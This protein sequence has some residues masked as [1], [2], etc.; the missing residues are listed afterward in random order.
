[1][2]TPATE[3]DRLTTLEDVRAHDWRMLV[4]GELVRARS[5][6]TVTTESPALE[7]P[8]A[9]VPEAD[10]EDI[11]AA[12]RAAEDGTAQWQTL[13]VQERA[14]RVRQMAERLAG[15]ADEFGFLDSLDGG[16][17]ITAMRGDVPLAVALMRM[18]CDWALELKGTTIP[19]T[20]DHLHYTVREPYGV[21][22]RIIPYNHPL[23]FA[24][25]RSAPAL[26]AG[27]AVI[28]KTPDQTP[29]SALRMGEL[30]HDLFPPGVLNI[31]TGRGAVTGDALVRHPR[32]KRIAFIGSVPT[33]QSVLRAASETGIKHVTLELG[34]KNPMIVFP[35]AD[36]DRAVEAAVLGMNFHWTG[37]QSCGSTS[38]LLLH[39]SL[40]DELVPRVVARVEEIKV[41]SPMDAATEMG[42][43]VSRA[44]YDKVMG[45]IE[46]G[47]EE[48]AKLL[49][50]GARP[51]GAE[52][53]KGWF[54][55]PTV[56]GNVESG[57]RIAQEEIFG[58]VLSILTYR[59]VDDAIRLANDVS[60]GLTAS[61]WTR[62]VTL[63]HRA[64]SQVQC[65]FVWINTTSRHYAGTP[66]GG[67]RN[68]GIGREEG[69][70][71]LLDFTQIKTV[72]LSLAV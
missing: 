39:E 49:T 66:F 17:P 20:P 69:I 60:Y 5:G 59:D 14:G 12:V 56:F 23:M 22:A 72:N 24:A 43:M 40:A 35:D 27:N 10:P 36:V 11:D 19:A 48:G 64:A 55:A 3:A 38:R 63:A 61:I 1:M 8:I 37:G 44:Q 6:A 50:G 71:E 57:M 67:Y 33:G 28:V 52:F 70:Q 31:L 15:R 53:D 7:E 32:I 4:G 2:T 18:Y 9:E 65:G 47:R 41:G 51:L 16:N 54:V 13:S 42:T 68:S 30:V 21:V 45:Y 46:L 25:A 26:V 58:P 29:L 34:G 62:D